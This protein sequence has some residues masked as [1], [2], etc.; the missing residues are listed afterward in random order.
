MK[1]HNKIIFV[2][3]FFSYFSRFSYFLFSS[4]FLYLPCRFNLLLYPFPRWPYALLC[5]SLRSCWAASAAAGRLLVRCWCFIVAPSLP[6][7]APRS[8]DPRRGA[9]VTLPPP[10]PKLVPKSG[11]AAARLPSWVGTVVLSFFWHLSE[12]LM[13]FV[14]HLSGK[15]DIYSDCTKGICWFTV[16]LFS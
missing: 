6:P 4:H 10:L 9:S 14:K 2:F 7:A 3:S 5:P 16:E 12:G 8:G 15:Q 13:L 11:R 1:I